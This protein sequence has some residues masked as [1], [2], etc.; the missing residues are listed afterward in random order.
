MGLESLI[1]TK[2]PGDTDTP[3]AE[4]ILRI[5]KEDCKILLIVF[6]TPSLHPPP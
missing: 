2:V 1:S 3:G 6:F 4:T 5:R